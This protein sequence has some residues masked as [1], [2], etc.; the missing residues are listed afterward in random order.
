[1]T[2]ETIDGLRRLLDRT[3]DSQDIEFLRVVL[4][5]VDAAQAAKADEAADEAQRC[6][7]CK[8]MWPPYALDEK[9]ACP[10]CNLDALYLRKRQW[11]RA[12]GL[13]W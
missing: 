13:E 8:C 2:T 7:R 3:N 4:V 11:R 1:M 12:Q 10:N 5:A 6:G 9:G